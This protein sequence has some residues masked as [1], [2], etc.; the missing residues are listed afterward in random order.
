[1]GGPI[2]RNMRNED[3]ARV[4][5]LC[6]LAFHGYYGKIYLRTREGLE[7]SLA[8]YPQ[9]C[10]VAEEAGRADGFI[11]SRKLGKLGWIGVFGVDPCMHGRSIGKPL[12]EAAYEA[13]EGDG[14]EIIGLETMP[15]SP[16]NVGLYLKYGFSMNHPALVLEKEVRGPAS[17]ANYVFT[18]KPDATAIARI[19]SAVID[20]LDYSPEAE[21]AEKYGWGKTF[22]FKGLT[23]EGFAIL[24]HTSIIENVRAESLF[25]RALVLAKNDAGDLAA[26][27][28]CIERHALALGFSKVTISASAANA[29]AVRWLIGAGYRVTK[30][31]MRMTR[32][33]DYRIKAGI[34]MSR[35]I[36]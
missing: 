17:Q 28:A 22:F 4:R 35:W 31:S 34:E 29:D 19:G 8:L 27:M 16:Y 3:L 13:L 7:S 18:E 10:F 25:V 9:G 5:E 1:M 36:M 21:N 26:V 24:R 6:A 33:G 2:I 32:K 14:C 12:L 20:G 15:D 11:F 30:T 23:S